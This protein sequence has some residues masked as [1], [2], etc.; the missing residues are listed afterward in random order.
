MGWNLVSMWAA[1][2]I[3]AKLVLLGLLAMAVATPALAVVALRHPARAQR[4]RGLLSIAASAPMLGLL[5]SVMGIINASMAVVML[6]EL[7]VRQLAAGL[8]EALVSTALGLVVGIAALWVRTAVHASLVRRELRA[9]E[10]A[11]S[12][13]APQEG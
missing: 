6:D 9:P 11:P 5:G 3:V 8:A 4:L 7:P 10:P 1:M 12:M 13:A 2:G